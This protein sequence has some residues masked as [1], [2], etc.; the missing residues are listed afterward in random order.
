MMPSRHIF[1]LYYVPDWDKMKNKPESRG[2]GVNSVKHS[3]NAR[4]HLGAG[5]KGGWETIS[6]KSGRAWGGGHVKAF[7]PI[8]EHSRGGAEAQR[9]GPFGRCHS[10]GAADPCRALG[11]AGH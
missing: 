10:H 8:W 7:Q 1:K 2:L 4:E 3:V 5:F 11:V 6:R 9:A